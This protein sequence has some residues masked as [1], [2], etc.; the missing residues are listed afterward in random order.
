MLLR[1]PLSKAARFFSQK[2]AIVCG[3]D[4][5]TYGEFA[6]RVNRLANGLNGLGI[7]KGGKLA[8]LHTNCHI[9]MEA[10]HGAALIGA[11]L[12]PVNYRLSPREIAFILEDSESQLLITSADF[13][14][15]VE[16]VRRGARGISKVLFSGNGESYEGV[17]S[18]S[19]GEPPPPVSMDGTDLAQ[20]YYT[21]GTTGRPKGVMLSRRVGDVGHHMGRGDPRDGSPF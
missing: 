20:I 16:G 18:Q 21:S 1:E 4:R 17:L 11:A 10:Y 12:V 15:I 9:F 13:K 3:E 6:G 7:G 14:P 5:F 19:S 8:I 2:E